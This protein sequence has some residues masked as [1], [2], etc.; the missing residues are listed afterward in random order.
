MRHTISESSIS[1]HI[2]RIGE[3]WFDLLA[4]KAKLIAG[5]IEPDRLGRDRVLEFPAK[6]RIETEPFDLRRAPLSCSIQIKSILATNDRV[7]LTLSVAERLA[8]D[9]RPV[10]ICILRVDE[11]DEIVDMHLVHLLGDNLSRVLKRLR[12]EFALGTE[13]LNKP[14]IT[15]G[16]AA[17]RK[18]ELTP[19]GLKAALTELIGEDMDAYGAEKLRQR[20]T[21][22][23]NNSKRYSMSVTFEEMTHGDLI[24]GMLGLKKLGVKNLQSFE[25][26]F[27]IKLPGG[28]PILSDFENAVLQI[29]PTPVDAGII[30]I[31]SPARDVPVE[32]NCDLIAPV[33]PKIPVNSM[34]VIARSELLDAVVSIE[35]GSI[36]LTNTDDGL[37]AHHLD[38]WWKLFNFWDAVFTEGAE[39]SVRT[40]GGHPLFSG[41]PRDAA[42]TGERPEYLNQVVAILGMARRLLKEAD[43]LDRPISLRNIMLSSKAIKQTHDFFFRA[44]ELD[45]FSFKTE[46]SE[47]L[48]AGE[49]PGL[50]VSTFQMGDD[51]YAYALKLALV[52]DEV[53][54]DFEF[55]STN[56]APLHISWIEDEEAALKKFAKQ[57]AKLSGSQITI[58]P[59][60]ENLD[61]PKSKTEQD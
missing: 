40:N 32:L 13:A 19:D 9:N 17:G 12:S 60:F 14:E 8:G 49:Y 50:F 35:D 47:R 25:E 23:Y 44:N 45:S 52:L 54:G 22:G 27:D 1:D 7:A 39:L 26:R 33:L 38:E 46:K 57:M 59:G 30:S 43:S 29:S 28:L 21:V 37:S 3:S 31:S 34:K 61:E 51:V 41:S 36:K 53:V 24:D 16:I 58:M 18:V 2:G 6:A 48:E 11:D 4:N 5:R 10:F 42:T 55:R 15:F 56:M 20:E